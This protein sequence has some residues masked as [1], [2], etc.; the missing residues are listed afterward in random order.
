LTYSS[1]GHPGNR[2]HDLTHENKVIVAVVIFFGAQAAL[3]DAQVHRIPPVIAQ[4]EVFRDP[5]A[6]QAVGLP[7][8]KIPGTG[9]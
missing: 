2:F 8:V 3:Q 1:S 6:M 9:F 5:D 7:G 4:V